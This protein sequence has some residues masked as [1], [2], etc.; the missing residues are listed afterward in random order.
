MKNLIPC[1]ILSNDYS[2][3]QPQSEQELPRMDFSRTDLYPV[4]EILSELRSRLS[5]DGLAVITAPPGAGKTTILP[6][7][8]L[9]EPWNVGKIIILE[10]QVSSRVR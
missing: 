2:L 8:L 4:L 6:I 7:A 3:F 10:T 9:H 1:G 5:S